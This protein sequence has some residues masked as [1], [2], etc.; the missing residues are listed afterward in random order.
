MNCQKCGNTIEV[1]RVAKFAEFNK[2]PK[3]CVACNKKLTAAKQ[4]KLKRLM[5]D[6]AM[7]SLGLTKVRGSVSGKV[8]WE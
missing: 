6:D 1:E 3:Y 2:T 7:R 5:Y 4:R 8:Y